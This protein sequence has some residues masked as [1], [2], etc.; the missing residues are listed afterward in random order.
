MVADAG[1]VAVGPRGSSGETPLQ[2][3]LA[4]PHERPEPL[5]VL[6]LGKTMM[7]AGRRVDMQVLADELGVNRVTLY[8]WVGSREQLLTEVLWAL[9]EATIERVWQ[10]VG[11][12]P[13]PRVPAA[14][15]QWI[16]LALD[17]PGVG[18][19]LA[20]EN[21]LAMRLFSSG[22]AGLQ[23]RLLTL[24]QEL[25]RRDIHEQRVETTLALDKLAF[26]VAQICQSGVYRMISGATADPDAVRRAVSVLLPERGPSE[27]SS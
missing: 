19:F 23:A 8:R 7:L 10:E 24:V 6:R 17:A 14:L 12:Q 5:D 26:A 13:G 3:Q 21:D 20:D 27:P 11:E 18:H 4:H 1:R 25:I 16:R 2:R 22:L 15:G 9:T